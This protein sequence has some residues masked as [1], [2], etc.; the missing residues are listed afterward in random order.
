VGGHAI[1]VVGYSKDDH[2]ICKNSW[3]DG[4]NGDGYVRIAQ[5]KNNTAETYIDCIDV[6]GVEIA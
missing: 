4:W 1:A 5:G 2:W 6:W 3:G